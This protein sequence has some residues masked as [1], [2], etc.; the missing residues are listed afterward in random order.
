M[1][2][3]APNT[4]STT[5]NC[6]YCLMCR[7]V[8]PVGHVLMLE[9]LTPHG[10]GMTIASVQRGLLTWNADTAAALYHCADCGTCQAHCVTDQPLPDAI[11]AARAE[12]AAL[13]QAPAG[14]YRVDAM[15][16]EWG[17]PFEKQA[18]SRPSGTGEIGLYV[19]D[20]AVY[21]WPQAL[22]AALKLLYAAGVDPVLIGKGRNNGYLASS[23]GLPD[24]AQALAQAT[25]DDLTTSGV[26]RLLVLAPGDAFAFSRL[27]GERLGVTWPA[28]VVV[29]EVT[30]FLAAQIDAGMLKLGGGGAE[31]H[32]S[33]GE[34]EAPP[35]AYLDPTHTVRME[36]RWEAPRR[37]LDAVMSGPRCELFWRKERAHPAGATALP[38]TFPYVAMML[39]AARLEDA[40]SAGAHVVV[41]EAPGDL[42]LL[43]PLAP[44]YGLQV[45]GLYELL[46]DHLS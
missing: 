20:E 30:A 37:L 4:G 13:G 14:V 8:C 3:E 11:A 27:Y 35:Y 43:T 40:K 6:R 1:Q 9:T 12:V 21:R 5:D 39:A 2:L 19:G 34:S 26:K 42:A 15:L 36:G 41:T 44:R 33:V 46:A 28:E 45:R 38:F 32:E 23:L 10:W 25:L 16:A 18:P 29:Q 7:H 31:A 22:E 24:R 17:N